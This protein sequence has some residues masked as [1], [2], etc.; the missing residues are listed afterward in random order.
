[1][2]LFFLVYTG[3]G[4]DGGLAPP[5]E[6]P[7]GT[8]HATIT[9]EGAW[10]PAD[11]LHDL[12]LVAMRFVPQDTSDFLQLNNLVFSPRSLDYFVEHDTVVVAEVDRGTY[13]Y[14]GVAQQY[15]ESIFAWRPVGLYS[16]QNGVF[17]IRPGDTTF[18]RIAVDFD[19]LPPFPP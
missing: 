7:V 13:V 11:S 1:M 8:L 16:E 6:P 3:M 15:D 4:C 9:Y 17:Q 19:H 12:R 18:I 10:P 2:L 5:D 14:T